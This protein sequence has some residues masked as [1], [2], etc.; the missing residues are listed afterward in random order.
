[1]TE[2]EFSKF[3]E[4]LEKKLNRE[5]GLC[6]SVRNTDIEN[7]SIMVFIGHKYIS[8]VQLEKHNR[9]SSEWNLVDQVWL[10]VDSLPMDFNLCYRKQDRG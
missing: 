7:F 10:S 1:M 8:G 6:T 3:Y 2:E 4:I 5:D 9:V